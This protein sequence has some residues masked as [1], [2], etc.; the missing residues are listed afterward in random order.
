MTDRII[1]TLG[2]D[3]LLNLLGPVTGGLMAMT[4]LTEIKWNDG[5]ERKSY[6]KLFPA[7]RELGFINE[8]TGF[9]L[10]KACGLPLP[11]HA[12][13]VKIPQGFLKP[14]DNI[15]SW[16]FAIS[17]VPGNSPTSMFNLSDKLTSKQAKPITDLLEAW[18]YLPN[19]FAFDDWTAN[20]DRNPGNLIVSNTGDICLIDHSNLPID[21][22]WQASDLVDDMHYSGWIEKLLTLTNSHDKLNKS[23]VSL[24]A[25]KHPTQ[26]LNA[27]KELT[28]WWDRYLASDLPRRESIE[29]FIE[30]RANSSHF[31]LS[32][33]FNILA[34]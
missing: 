7:D 14:K 21:I 11:S 24:A 17:E 25:S 18:K 4:W 33:H 1:E 19:C 22:K 13:M 26:Y 15:S 2:E 5:I 23:K 28:F 8:I 27:I 34:V 16:A 10:A 32:S 20:L 31:R 29:R 9:L 3:N 30:N 6:I 12:G